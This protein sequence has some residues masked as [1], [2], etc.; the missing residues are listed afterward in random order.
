MVKAHHTCVVGDSG[1]GKTTLVRQIHEEF[2]KGPSLW[3]NHSGEMNV[4][5]TVARSPGELKQ[6]VT[7][8]ESIQNLRVNYKPNVDAKEACAVAR[9]WA[10]E[11][12]RYSGFPVQVVVDE[13]VAVLPDSE[14]ESGPGNPVRD[15]LH[16]DRDQ[17]IKWVLATQDPMDLFYPPIKQCRQIIWVGIPSP[18]HQGFASYF[19]LAKGAM[20]TQEYAYRVFRKERPFEWTP[21]YEGTTEERYAV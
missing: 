3:V 20:P 6:V 19:N 15:G 16:E 17:K 1:S 13:A 4:A 11:L 14:S 9:A 21:V 2:E 5:G 7:R 18:F 12:R 8:A 10:K